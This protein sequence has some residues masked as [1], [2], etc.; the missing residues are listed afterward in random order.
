[1]TW[2]GFRRLRLPL[3]FHLKTRDRRALWT[4]VIGVGIGRWFIGVICGDWTAE[5]KPV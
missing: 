3:T 4:H 5:E 1:M 2:Y